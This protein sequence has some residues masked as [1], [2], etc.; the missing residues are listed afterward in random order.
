MMD[1]LSFK[2]IPEGTHRKVKLS[3]ID[4]LCEVRRRKKRDLS[5]GLDCKFIDLKIRQDGYDH[6]IQFKLSH[7]KNITWTWIKQVYFGGALTFCE[8]MSIS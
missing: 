2:Q 7:Q 4:W 5:I 3:Y 6:L 8:Y 1:M